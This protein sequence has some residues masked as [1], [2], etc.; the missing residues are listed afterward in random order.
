MTLRL[1]S[2]CHY[3]PSDEL[4]H[5]IQS[6]YDEWTLSPNVTHLA[7]Y[8][9]MR[10]QKFVWLNGSNTQLETYGGGDGT[11]NIEIGFEYRRPRDWML[12]CKLYN[13]RR[14]ALY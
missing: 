3:G 10:L 13:F 4:L 9:D 5:R 7:I 8:W 12:R 1:V 14:T 2:V 11:N 6:S